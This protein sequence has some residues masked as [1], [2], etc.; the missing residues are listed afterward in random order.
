MSLSHRLG[1]LAA[2][3]GLAFATASYA[4]YVYDPGNLDESPTA[5]RYFGSIK[6]ERGKPLTEAGIIAQQSYVFM[7]DVTGRFTGHAPDP[8]YKEE[9]IGCSKPGYTIVRV[10]KRFGVTNKKNWVQVDCVLRKPK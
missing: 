2:V 7:T 10:N 9:V 6:D 5:T 4:Q 3:A 1:A 8:W